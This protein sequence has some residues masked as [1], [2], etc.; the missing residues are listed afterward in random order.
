MRHT[1]A[2]GR[3][4]RRKTPDI[5]IGTAV[6]AVMAARGVR[7]V[8]GYKDTTRDNPYGCV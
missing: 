5:D 3:L 8:W 4:Q 6:S 1:S 7:G 2:G